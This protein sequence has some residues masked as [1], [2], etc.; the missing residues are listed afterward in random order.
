MQAYERRRD[1]TTRERFEVIRHELIR[2]LRRVCA[3]M[4]EGELNQLTAR[5][6]RIRLKYEPLVGMP[7]GTE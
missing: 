5:M 2:R 4:A 7:V 3:E 6:T 1:L